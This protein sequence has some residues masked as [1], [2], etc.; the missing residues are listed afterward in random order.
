MIKLK[1]LLSEIQYQSSINE[2]PYDS[3]DHEIVMSVLD[4]A[5]QFTSEANPAAN[6]QWDSIEDLAKYI[7]GDFIDQKWHNDFDDGIERVKQRHNIGSGNVDLPANSYNLKMLS[8]D[9]VIRTFPGD[10]KNVQFNRMQPDGKTGP[11][12]EDSVAFPTDS[13]SSDKIGDLSDFE[14][15]K[16]PMLSKYGNDTTIILDPDAKW[17]DK[18]KIQ[19]DKFN[20][21]SNSASSAKSSTLNQWGTTE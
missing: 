12:Y 16:K 5:G 8:F 11:Y 14:N 21:Q 19:S 4:V 3:L 18:V 10:Y 7:K 17:F 1:T 15:W 13:D 6:Q 20:K 2:G 9:D